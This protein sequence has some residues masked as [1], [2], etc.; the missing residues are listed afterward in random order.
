MAAV[1]VELPEG[2]T[3]A[4]TRGAI[5]RA[6]L[7]LFAESGYSAVSIR[8]IANEVGITSASLYAHYRSKDHILAELVL[9]GHRELHARLTN[10][11]AAAEPTAV[12]QLSA[13]VRAH[14]LLHTDFPL[15]A[16]V[17]NS[18]LHALPDE[19]AA[20][21]LELRASCSRLL[22]DTLELGVRDGVFRIENLHLGAVA[23]G[24]MAIQVAQWFG[25]DEPFTR[26]EVADNYVHYALRIVGADEGAVR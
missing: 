23:I 8:K 17:T 16:V 14:V 24:G 1:P 25:P 18:E 15:L 21:A 5:L 7:A 20:P 22:L 12:A 19:L 6:S 11:L 10:A 4:G 3:P 26:D 9:T 2:V 13:L